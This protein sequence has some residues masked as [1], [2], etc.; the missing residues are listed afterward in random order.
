MLVLGVAWALGVLGAID[1]LAKIRR[2]K[3]LGLNK[4]AKFIGQA[5]V[6]FALAYARARVD[7]LDVRISWA[8]RRLGFLPT[9]P[10]I[11][12]ALVVVFLI[13]REHPTA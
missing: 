7:G 12:F 3:S 8:G 5:I 13:I 2:M 10:Q 6:G 9:L 11:L 4:R 1:D